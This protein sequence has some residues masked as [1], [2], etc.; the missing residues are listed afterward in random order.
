MD[1]HF[2]YPDRFQRYNG[3]FTVKL[4]PGTTTDN[5][6]KSVANTHMEGDS[7]VVSVTSGRITQDVD[8]LLFRDHRGI[9]FF[10]SYDQMIAIRDQDRNHLW[11]NDDYRQNEKPTQSAKE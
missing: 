5:L 10:W 9:Q 11:S 3:N 8:G 6:P 2:Q 4:V 7:V 1:A